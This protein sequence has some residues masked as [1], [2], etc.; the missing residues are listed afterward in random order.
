MVNKALIK[1]GVCIN[2]VVVEEGVEHDWFSDYDAVVDIPDGFWL[3]DSYAGGVWSK[4]SLVQ[5]IDTNLPQ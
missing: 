5:P 1:N 2:V 3:G 4:N